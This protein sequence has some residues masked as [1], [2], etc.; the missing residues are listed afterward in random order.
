MAAGITVKHGALAEFRAYLERELAEPVAAARS[1]QALL[2]DGAVSAAGANAVLVE[3]IAR[4]GPF[5]AGNPE[6]VVALPHHV[7]WF[8]FAQA[9]AEDLKCLRPVYLKRWR[10]DLPLC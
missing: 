10:S 3:T 6:P 7:V 2:I 4:A 8:L 5:G 1:D 9:Q